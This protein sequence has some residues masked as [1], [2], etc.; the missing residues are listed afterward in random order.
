M[1]GL[2]GKSMGHGIGALGLGTEALVPTI[3]TPIWQAIQQTF[4]NLDSRHSCFF[5]LHIHCDD[6]YALQLEKLGER[7]PKLTPD[8]LEGRDEALSL[9]HC[10][11]DCMLERAWRM[12]PSDATTL[13]D[14]QAT[15]WVR[16]EP[17]CLSDFTACPK[18]LQACEPVANRTILIFV[19]VMVTALDC[20]WPKVQLPL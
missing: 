5:P 16:T 10:F 6:D 20:F 4:P 8:I 7:H 13:Y 14:G 11:W 17:T 12:P 3:Y 9:R 1:L 18:V 15:H 19:A 2:C